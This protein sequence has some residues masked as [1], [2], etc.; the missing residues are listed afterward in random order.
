MSIMMSSKRIV[1][2]D[3]D[4]RNAGGFN[5]NIIPL[6][7][8]EP[9]FSI[10]VQEETCMNRLMIITAKEKVSLTPERRIRPR[11]GSGSW[12]PKSNFNMI[13]GGSSR[14]FD[15]RAEGGSSERNVDQSFR[16]RIGRDL[17]FNLDGN[18]H[19]LNG[20]LE[21]QASLIM[22]DLLKI[23][24]KPVDSNFDMSHERGEVDAVSPDLWQ[25]LDNRQKAEV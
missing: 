19:A 16:D 11:L 13:D 21:G 1:Y 14:R 23:L 7:E 9:L 20:P 18:I 3:R 25:D 5:R 6:S 8:V 12:D 17:D 2:F 4:D 10:K 22:A 24:D 15:R